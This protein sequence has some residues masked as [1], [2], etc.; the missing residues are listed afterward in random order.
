MLF[1][2][3]PDS[4][5]RDQMSTIIRCVKIDFEAKKVEICESFLGYF[6]I[7]GHD[8]ESLTNSICSYLEKLNLCLDDCCCQVYDNT[9][10]MAGHISG[11]QQRILQKNPKALF[12]NCNNHSLNLVGVH[13]VEDEVEMVIFFNTVRS[14]F[15]FFNASPQRWE[16]LKSSLKM[17]LKAESTTRWSARN[18]AVRAIVEQLKELIGLLEEMSE[19]TTLTPETMAGARRILT[20]EF[21]TLIHFWSKVLSPLDR[22]QKRLQSK[23]MNFHEAAKDLQALAL[24]FNEQRETM[25]AEAI[26][27][28]QNLCQE[29]DVEVER[30]TRAAKGLTKVQNL[31][32]VMKASMDRLGSEMNDRFKRTFELDNKFGFLL[33]TTT[34]INE[35]ELNLDEA[36]DPIAEFLKTEIEKQQ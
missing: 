31:N 30:R 17:L 36:C 8:S 26:E 24:F 21:L 28:G 1:D 15:T 18:E 23:D 25:V 10:N 16:K 11:V 33:D 9:N 27:K 20:I 6:E 4:A 35:T 7:Q 5:R 19:D 29:Y 32:R 13:S 3:T 22:V 2:S 12:I 14:L 34:L